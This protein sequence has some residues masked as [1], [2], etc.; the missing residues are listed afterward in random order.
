M[1]SKELTRI[2]L[3]TALIAIGAFITIP[4]GPVPFT[5]QTLFVILAGL[6][7]KPS[8][9]GLSAFLYMLIGLIGV[10]IFAGFSGGLQSIASPTFGFIISFIPMAYI[11]S[12]FGHGSMDNKKIILGIL[13]GVIVSYILGLI[14]L[15]VGLTR[16]HGVEVP[17]SK[18]I[19]LGLIPFIIPDT[20]KIILAIIIYKRT[21]KYISK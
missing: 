21:Y 2:A 13:I 8:H 9:A 15:K 17:M 3:S 5:L 12:K 18:V 16:V 11:I 1:T 20:I 4:L 7:L 14:Y 10:P 6:F 19:S